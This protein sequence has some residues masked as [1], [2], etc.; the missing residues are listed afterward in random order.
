MEEDYTGQEETILRRAD[1]RIELRLAVVVSDMS[2]AVAL[3]SIH[4]C[5]M[6]VRSLFH[7]GGSLPV[8]MELEGL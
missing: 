7:L 4:I 2:K 1:P 3:Q 5:A 8:Q 6:V